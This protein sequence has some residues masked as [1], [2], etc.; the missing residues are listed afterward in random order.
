MAKKSWQKSRINDDVCHLLVTT[1]KEKLFKSNH[2]SRF[3]KDANQGK[4]KIPFI[5]IPLAKL[6]RDR[7]SLMR[8]RMLIH[9]ISFLLL[10]E[11]KLVNP[12]SKILDLV[13]L[14]VYISSYSPISF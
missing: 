6:L 3:Q 2:L 4:N 9:R 14:S 1:V 7:Y 8:N 10:W 13:K 11:C 12:L 5:F